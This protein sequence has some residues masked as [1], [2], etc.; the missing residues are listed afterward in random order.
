[1]RNH[2]L[3]LVERVA[4]GARCSGAWTPARVVSQSVSIVPKAYP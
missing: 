1:M 2:D 4:K 3:Y